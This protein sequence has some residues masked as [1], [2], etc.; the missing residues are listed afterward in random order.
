[1]WSAPPRSP[2]L[3]ARRRRVRR[4]RGDRRPGA[5][6]GAHQAG[7]ITPAQDRL[8]FVAF[9]VITDQRAELIALLK[10][11]DHGRRP[12]DG[13]AGRRADRRGERPVE[14]PPDDTGEA[15][16]LTPA[17]LTLTFGFGTSLFK[18]ATAGPVSAWLPA[19]GRPDGPA[20]LRPG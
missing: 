4:Y 1:V 15:L 10:A 17:G 13:R 14:A 18:D 12:D 6:H 7:I 2:S 5:V 20:G 8:H 19:A 11:V 9:D 3:R 16:G